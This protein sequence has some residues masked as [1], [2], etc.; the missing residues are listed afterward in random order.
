MQHENLII[1]GGMK[2]PTLT[3]GTK[4]QRPMHTTTPHSTV[5]HLFYAWGNQIQS[6]FGRNSLEGVKNYHHQYINHHN[7]E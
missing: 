1:D 5:L 4:I 6:I 7:V 2:I 3:G